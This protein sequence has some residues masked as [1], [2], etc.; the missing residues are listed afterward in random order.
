VN[1]NYK[2]IGETVNDLIFSEYEKIKENVAN[3]FVTNDK[4]SRILKY[5]CE[6]T[7]F[8]VIDV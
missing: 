1:T 4:K 7:K 8:K 6:F 2:D 5:I 3:N